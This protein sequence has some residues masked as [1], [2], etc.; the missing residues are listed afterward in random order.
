MSTAV[1]RN[2]DAL[3]PFRPGKDGPWDHSAAAHLVRRAAFG[4]PPKQVARALDIGP[5]A[6]VTDLLAPREDNDGLHNR[7]GWTTSYRVD[8]QPGRTAVVPDR[9]ASHRLMRN[10]SR[11]DLHRLAA[12]DRQWHDSPARHS[13]AQQSR[14]AGNRTSCYRT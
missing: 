8:R 3:L 7:R 10:W 4:A 1:R 6:A 2:S 5:A 11:H 14:S 9:H 12:T 13:R